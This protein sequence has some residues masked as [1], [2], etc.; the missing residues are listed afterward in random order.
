MDT[1]SLN[2]NCNHTFNIAVIIPTYNNCKTVKGVIHGVQKYIK[3]IIAINDGST[4]RTSDILL[5]IQGIEV[6]SFQKNS[7]KGIALTQGFQKAFKRNFTHVITIDSDGQHI[8]EDIPRLMEKIYEGPDVLWVGNR[9][10]PY[11]KGDT[12]PY[13]SSFGRKFGTFWYKFNTGITLN[14]T[15]S[16]FRAYPLSSILPIKCSGKRY[17]YEQEILIK[18]AWNDIPVKEVPIRLYYPSRKNSTSH[19][20]PIR[21]FL[22]ISHVNAKA[23]MTRM[24]L[25]KELVKSPGSSLKEKITALIK[26][27]IRANATPKKAAFSLSTG[28]FI[29]IFP[30]HLFQVITFL[31]LSY[32]LKLNRPL[33]YLGVS[34]SSPPIMPLIII[35]TVGIGR[36]VVMLDFLPLIS[37][38]TLS[39]AAKYGIEFIIGSIVLA[40][41]AACTT[42][43]ISFPIFKKLAKLKLYKKQKA[44]H[45]R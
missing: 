20:R 44:R 7:G 31:G 15:Q 17:E 1:N 9:T 18:A 34:I 8:V 43:L 21:D 42:F 26:Y 27:E 12:P 3:D 4:D 24:F 2:K 32:I 41:V 14:D 25:P 13:R 33:G 36:I 45:D 6:L 23:A 37:T 19:F 28:V 39:T 29:G 22:R 40:P 5:S 10:L 16:G 35:I 30:I 38:N 11:D